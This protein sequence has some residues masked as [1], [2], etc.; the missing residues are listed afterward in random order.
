MPLKLQISQLGVKQQSCRAAKSSTFARLHYKLLQPPDLK[1]TQQACHLKCVEWMVSS[2]VLKEGIYN[3]E[4]CQ[5]Y[6][7]TLR[8]H[9]I[10]HRHPAICVH[11]G[12]LGA[13]IYGCYSYYRMDPIVLMTAIT[14][15]KAAF[16]KRSLCHMDF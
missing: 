10:A 1:S 9:C 7:K 14:K 4:L 15:I 12:P 6:R 5:L 16:E 11:T 13:S 3:S 2:R 8:R